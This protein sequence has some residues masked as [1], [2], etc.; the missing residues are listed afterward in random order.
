MERAS[1]A[2]IRRNREGSGLI[3]YS[4]YIERL[5]SGQL[6]FQTK[7]VAA[8][9]IVIHNQGSVIKRVGISTENCRGFHHTR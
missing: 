6:T 5:S 2:G 8:V 4:E 7:I 9:I 1:T 3:L